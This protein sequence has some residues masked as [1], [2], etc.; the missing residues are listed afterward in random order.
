MKQWG[1][2]L[3]GFNHNVIHRDMVDL[4]S[5]LFC[6]ARTSKRQRKRRGTVS[7]STETAAHFGVLFRT[8]ATIQPTHQATHLLFQTYRSGLRRK[9]DRQAPCFVMFG[10]QYFHAQ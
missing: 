4:A 8:H 9:C 3:Q 5:L 2:R 7:I 1:N 10:R 6:P